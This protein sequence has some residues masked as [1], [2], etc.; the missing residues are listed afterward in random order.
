MVNATGRHDRSAA[1]AGPE[2]ARQAHPSQAGATRAQATQEQTSPEQAR[3][4]SEQA[5]PYSGAID[6]GAP[7]AWVV[8]GDLT[9]SVHTGHLVAL[10]AEGAPALQV[11]SPEQVMYPR[12]SIKPVQALAALRTGVPLSSE[13]IAVG[14]ASHSGEPEHLEVVRSILA[15]AGLS[16][17][18]LANTPD[19]PLSARAARDAH[20]AGTAPS[21]LAQNCSGKHAVMLAACVHNG[22]PTGSYLRPDHPLQQAIAQTVAE[23]TGVPVAHTAVDGCGAPLLSTTTTGLARSFAT[24]AT[25]ATGTPEA[26]IASAMAAHPQLVGGTGRDVSEAMRQIP[27]LIAK[28]GAEG[29]YAAALPDGRAVALKIADGASRPRPVALAAALQVLGVRPEPLAAS[30]PAE[31]RPGDPTEPRP[32]EPTEPGSGEPAEQVSAHPAGHP[33][34]WAQVPV[35]GHGRP[36]GQVIPAFGPQAPSSALSPNIPG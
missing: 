14:C 24:L 1:A 29:V 25:A 33:W 13:Q 17:A 31:L 21:A 10:S 19:R 26:A 3:G 27:G 4:S 15:R 23:L 32:E 34:Q 18:D 22:W 5:S 35:L 30:E 16:E 7:L 11:G 9:E 20:A 28:D 36:A 6:P 2:H 8:R 12:S